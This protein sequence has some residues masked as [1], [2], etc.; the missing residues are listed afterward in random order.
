MVVI[1]GDHV[2]AVLW[3]LDLPSAKRLGKLVRYIKV[4]FHTFLYVGLENIV[5]YAEDF[6]TYTNWSRDYLGQL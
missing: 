3:N 6:V 5:R 1:R 4:L 2:T